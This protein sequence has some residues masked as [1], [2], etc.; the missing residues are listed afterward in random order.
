MCVG[1]T[2]LHLLQP[3]GSVAE[4]TRF[5]VA[6]STVIIMSVNPPNLLNLV[7]RRPPMHWQPHRLAWWA[8]YGSTFMRSMALG[9]NIRYYYDDDVCMSNFFT[10]TVTSRVGGRKN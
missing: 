6:H 7:A 8:N 3:A 5:A 2:S 4:R 10:S 1:V 9:D